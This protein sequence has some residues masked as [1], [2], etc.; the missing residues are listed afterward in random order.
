MKEFAALRAKTYA[1]NTDD[2]D[3]KKRA[4]GTKSA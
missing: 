2:D 1:Y 3:E 4:K